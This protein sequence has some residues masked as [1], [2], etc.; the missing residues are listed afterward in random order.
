MVASYICLVYI[1]LRLCSE[2]PYALCGFQIII[3]DLEM[4]LACLL[5]WSVSGKSGVHSVN[6][7]LVLKEH[8]HFGLPRTSNV[9][10]RY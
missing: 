4:K 8:Y 2:D 5:T 10:Y 9:Q 1:W 6:A 7:S 3:Q